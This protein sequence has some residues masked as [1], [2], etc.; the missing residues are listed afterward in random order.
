[1]KWL[2]VCVIALVA[3]PAFTYPAAPQNVCT[4]YQNTPR[5]QPTPGLKTIGFSYDG[6]SLDEDPD[7]PSLPELPPLERAIK[8]WQTTCQDPYAAG[9]A[10][11]YP[12]RHE[13][14]PGESKVIVL[15]DDGI[16]GCG[17][18]VEGPHGY[19]LIPS[20]EGVSGTISIASGKFEED[21]DC[22]K[23]GKALHKTIA[24]EIGHVLS[25]GH[26]TLKEENTCLMY[27]PTSPEF[28]PLA[29]IGAPEPLECEKVA[30]NW[31]VADWELRP[32][33]SALPTGGRTYGA[34]GL[35]HN[36]RLFVGARNKPGSRE[37]TGF[38][39]A[40]AVDSSVDVVQ[41]PNIVSMKEE[42]EFRG[43]TGPKTFVINETSSRAAFFVNS[44]G[45]LSVETLV[46]ISLP[47][48]QEDGSFAG[49]V[50]LLGSLTLDSNT[51]IPGQTEPV[52]VDDYV[53]WPSGTNS[54]T[55]GEI[56]VFDMSGDNPTPVQTFKDSE[57]DSVRSVVASPDG[58]YLY[59]IGDP[60][61]LALERNTTTGV[62]TRRGIVPVGLGYYSLGLLNRLLFAVVRDSAST[63]RWATV[64][65][66]EDRFSL[67]VHRTD[68]INHSTPFMFGL[69][70]TIVGGRAAVMAS[71]Q[72]PSNQNKLLYFDVKDRS[73]VTFVA[74]IPVLNTLYW[75]PQVTCS[76]RSS[77]ILVQSDLDPK[78]LLARPKF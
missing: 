18:W 28:V 58:N 13:E 68:T 22:D 12:T 31:G 56:F 66:G 41:P 14:E 47:I 30:E 10:F 59:A 39:E 16:E 50:S 4:S 67:T 57:M 6:G 15:E 55:G 17:L 34:L 45:G 19:P 62:L 42:P 35:A 75:A 21:G 25:L 65:I 46:Q 53:Y 70:N 76:R 73:N 23:Y 20:D 49:N 36:R 2:T 8:A 51:P 54:P 77:R 7:G 29:N 33:S 74:E 37:K 52:W 61:I 44:P 11:P 63:L 40:Y 78:V 24:H 1:M 60:A 26:N 71:D 32:R 72:A 5:W 43:A 9:I 69:C 48:A 38:V 64:D 27:V 3:T